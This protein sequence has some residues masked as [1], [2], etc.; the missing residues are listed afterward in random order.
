MKF[1]YHSS[2][3][4]KYNYYIK[5]YINNKLLKQ[6]ASVR[7]LGILIDSNLNWKCHITHIC[8]N[9]WRGVGLLSKIRCYVE[10][11]ILAMLY[12]SLIHPFLIYSLIAWGNT[13]P[14]ST[15]N[16]HI[17]K[18]QKQKQTNNKKQQQQPKKAIRI[19]TFSRFG[20]HTSPLFKQ[21]YLIKFVDLVYLFT[22]SITHV[23]LSLQHSSHSIQWFLFSSVQ[24]A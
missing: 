9:I 2:V 16:S 15:N 7:H 17:T 5:L 22:H 1:R 10:N 19:M 13:Y 21:L 14:T 11:H 6:E 18:K 20:T 23:P 3:T 8:K 4:K 12:Y 24:E